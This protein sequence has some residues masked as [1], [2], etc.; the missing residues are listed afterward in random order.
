MMTTPTM[1]K[2]STPWAR[3]AQEMRK[4]AGDSKLPRT[5]ASANA[6]VDLVRLFTELDADGLSIISARNAAKVQELLN[7]LIEATVGGHGMFEAEV[8]ADGSINFFGVPDEVS[9][10]LLRSNHK[11]NLRQTT[12]HKSVR[13][14]ALQDDESYAVLSL[15]EAFE[16]MLEIKDAAHEALDV[17]ALAQRSKR[18][19]PLF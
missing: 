4:L 15:L 12:G 16:V 18:L 5:F 14:V 8:D 17:A 10:I 9:E 3:Y 6:L 1:K 7:D 13:I 19:K 11:E 2:T